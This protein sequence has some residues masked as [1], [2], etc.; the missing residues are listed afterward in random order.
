MKKALSLLLM[1]SLLLCCTGAGFPPYTIS[2]GAASAAGYTLTTFDGET[3]SAV[4]IS[5]HKI[6]VIIFGSTVDSGTDM[7][8]SSLSNSTLVSVP[9]YQFIFAD[10]YD[11]P[12]SDVARLTEGYS[13]NI[14]FCY[15]NYSNIMWNLIRDKGYTSVPVPTIVFIDHSGK[16]AEVAPSNHSAADIRQIIRNIL[17]DEYIEPPKNPDFTTAE[18]RG[19]YYTNIQEALDRINAIRYEACAE[20]VENPAKPSTPLTLSDYHPLVWSSGLEEIARLRAAEATIR[21]GHTRP[22]G[23]RCFTANTMQVKSVAENLAWNYGTDMVEGIDQFYSE[24]EDWVNKTD[25]D[26]GHYTSMINP[27]Y[28]CAGVAGFYSNCGPLPSCLCFWLSTGENDNDRTFGKATETISVPIEI[29]S[30]YLSNPRLIVPQSMTVGEMSEP[31]FLADTRID[32]AKGFVYLRED[33]TWD[34][35]DKSILTVE[36]GTVQAVGGGIASVTATAFCGLTASARI[37]ITAAVTEPPANPTN[38]PCRGDTDGDG[39]VTILDATA[40]QRVLANLENKTFFEAAADA[41]AD[42]SVT[43]LDATSIQRHIAGLP[44][45][46]GIGRPLPTAATAAR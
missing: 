42:G 12:K 35:S 20:G 33:V 15:G 26:T 14:K 39:I 36:D 4:P 40:I 17:G 19:F 28:R 11:S 29:Q 41:D 31:D 10:L 16:V 30:R 27:T 6:S 8:L 3:I 44:A 18:V 5:P 43:I 25:G 9:Q 38:E 23:E 32:G 46:E 7:T 37:G 13:S 21:I 34:S 1:L 2:A 45:Y 24:K 22:N